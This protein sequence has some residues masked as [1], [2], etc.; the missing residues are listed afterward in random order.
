MAT[1]DP[2]VKV[3][4]NKRLNQQCIGVADTCGSI[5]RGTTD[6]SYPYGKKPQKAVIVG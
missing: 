4:I 5:F 1:F 2:T 6:A 3:N